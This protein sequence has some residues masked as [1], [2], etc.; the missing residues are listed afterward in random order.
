MYFLLRYFTVVK[1]AN[2]GSFADSR[3]KTAL[4]GSS[5]VT[6]IFF[7]EPKK[8]RRTAKQFYE[9]LHNN[10]LYG[11][12]MKHSITM[13]FMAVLWSPIINHF[14]A[15]PKNIHRTATGRQLA[16]LDQTMSIK[17]PRSAAALNTCT[18]YLGRPR[19]VHRTAMVI[20]FV[21]KRYLWSAVRLP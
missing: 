1:S 7:A 3:H 4:Y 11:S 16:Y 5:T 18:D 21:N 17:L 15:E 14:L 6:K 2:L 20:S 10:A 12:L 9:T 8:I 19:S 13:L